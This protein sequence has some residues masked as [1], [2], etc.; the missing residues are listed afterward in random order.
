MVK[1]LID[2]GADP[3]T[4][5][6]DGNSSYLMSRLV[7]DRNISSLFNESSNTGVHSRFAGNPARVKELAG[8]LAIISDIAWSRGRADF[9]HN[10]A[11]SGREGLRRAV[12][13]FRKASP[14]SQRVSALGHLRSLFGS[15]PES[16]Q[17]IMSLG[18]P[19]TIEPL[20]T[21]LEKSK[22]VVPKQQLIATLFVNS[23]QD[24]LREAGMKWAADNGFDV[25]AWPSGSSRQVWGSF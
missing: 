13:R 24:D 25:D 12:R 20:T 10:P 4:M 7:G 23:G 16:A 3:G 8:A 14:W 5:D 22:F 1:Y 21:L 9:A 2:N 6:V 18:I 19:A 17:F 15:D 11:F